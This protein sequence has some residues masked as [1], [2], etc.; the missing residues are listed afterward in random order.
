MYE[1][2]KGRFTKRG[3]GGE[4]GKEETRFRCGEYET[5]ASHVGGTLVAAWLRR[6]PELM[7]QVQGRSCGWKDVGGLLCLMSLA[8]RERLLRFY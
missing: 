8:P 3:L 7:E 4:M 2:V 1:L 5:P 6:G